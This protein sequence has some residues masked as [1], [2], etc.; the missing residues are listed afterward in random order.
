MTFATDINRIANKLKVSG[1]QMGR[2]VKVELLSSII[3]DTRVR[4]GRLRGNWQTSEGSPK[5]GTLD[6]LDPSGSAARADVQ[7]V[8]GISLTYM[9][10]NLPY[11]P[12]LEER[13]AMVGRNAARIQRIVAAEAAK[14]N[15]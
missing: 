7:G 5:G 1:E 4:T 12:V 9:A 14:V 2:A 6:R 8:P 15:K 3:N 10:N 13:D 11:A